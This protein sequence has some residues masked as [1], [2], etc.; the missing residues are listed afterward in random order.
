MEITSLGCHTYLYDMVSGD[1]SSVAI[2]LEVPSRSPEIV[3]V[4]KAIGSLNQGKVCVTPGIHDSNASLLP[5]IL[6]E[7]G[8]FVL[9]ST[10]T[11][12]VFMYP[13]AEF[14]PSRDDV[15]RDV[16]YYLD[17]FGRPIKSAR[18]KCGHEFDHYVRVIREHFGINP[19]EICLEERVAVDTLKQR[20][21]FII[22]TL[23]PGSGQFP[24][25]KGRIVGNK[26]FKDPVVAYHILN[27]SLAVQSYHALRILTGGVRG[28]RIIVQGGFAK[29]DV[30]LAYLATLM[31]D[32]EIVRAEYPEATSLGAAITA[33]C[34]LEELKPEEVEVP[35]LGG[36][37][38]GPISV[39][40]RYVEEY[41]EEFLKLCR[42][43]STKS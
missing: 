25:S 9:A 27:L 29:N 19:L 37:R 41:V 30:Y 39:D 15:Y 33:K 31:P 1:W 38:I 6:R 28:T 10:G 18:F 3:E 17:A 26:F 35:E 40:E 23:I 4:W 22:P 8:D 21:S 13:S 5:Y 34:A 2:G 7:K 24:Y 42:E 43:G 20:E 36:A 11:W 14:S 16:L 32:C 12:C